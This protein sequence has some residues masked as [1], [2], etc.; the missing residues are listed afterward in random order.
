[1]A[2]ADARQAAAASGTMHVDS[3]EEVED[4][5]MLHEFSEQNVCSV[6]P[7]VEC[8]GVGLIGCSE[9]DNIGL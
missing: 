6:A 2:V 8:H 1:M 4:V 5:T 9:R 3:K 7:G